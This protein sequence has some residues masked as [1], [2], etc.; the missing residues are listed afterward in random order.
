MNPL[1]TEETGL[2]I[3]FGVCTVL[4]LAASIRLRLRRN[5][6]PLSTAVGLLCGLAVWIVI[7]V[8]S[9][10]TRGTQGYQLGTWLVFAIGGLIPAGLVGL[11]EGLVASVIIRL[12]P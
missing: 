11:I 7:A 12:L 9:L 6:I 1:G 3:L 2:I 5:A 8:L 4:V 10:L